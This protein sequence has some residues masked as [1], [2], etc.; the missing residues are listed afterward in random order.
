MYSIWYLCSTLLLHCF[1]FH[2]APTSM[3]SDD[4]E[5]TTTSVVCAGSASA[6][7]KSAEEGTTESISSVVLVASEDLVVQNPFIMYEKLKESID[8]FWPSSSREER[9]RLVN[10]HQD[11]MLHLAN[12]L[13]NADKQ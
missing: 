13:L 1:L 4:L 11:V 8:R 7:L 10:A 3:D 9:E 2:T 6:E 12:K 5:A